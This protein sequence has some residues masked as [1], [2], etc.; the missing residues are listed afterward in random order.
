MLATL[1]EGSLRVDSLDEAD[2]AIRAGIENVRV[3][4]NH[5][6]ESE[7][8]RMAAALALAWPSPD[9]HEAERQFVKA[10]DCGRRYDHRLS[11]LR[12]VMGLAR[13]W[14]RQ[15]RPQDAKRLLGDTYSSFTQG[16][17]AFDLV[18]ARDLLGSIP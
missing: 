3:T 17:D 8:Y 5:H 18:A 2:A 11:V 4:G 6:G 15:G 12:A 10:I 16:L 9:E 13:L 1:A 7:L 14:W